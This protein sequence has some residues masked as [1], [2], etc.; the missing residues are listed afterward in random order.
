LR[1]YD[2]RR[3]VALHPRTPEILALRLVPGLYWQDLV[4]L[5]LDV[6][7]KPLVRRAADLRLLERLPGLA[8]GE[9][10][11]LARRGGPAVLAELRK[12]PTPRV[13]AAMLENPRLTEGILLPLLVGDHAAGAVLALV[14]SNSRFGSRYP[15][16]AGG[17]Q[18][19]HAGG[20]ALGLLPGL[21]KP[22][23]GAVRECAPLPGC[24]SARLLLGEF[25]HD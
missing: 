25:G 23:L 15:D 21:R 13:I 14:A 7:V 18:N 5:G 16:A 24:A 22:D 9:R 8:V 3:D 20:V 17:G 4:R 10:L 1:S 19:P 2:F 6:R 11:A 12:D